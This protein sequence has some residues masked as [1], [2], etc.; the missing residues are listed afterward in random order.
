MSGEKFRKA[1]S[2]ALLTEYESEI[3]VCAK[4]KFSD[5]FEAE[6]SKLI[7]H[8]RKICYRLTNTRKKKIA[9]ISAAAVTAA[10]IG[11]ISILPVVKEKT[12][13]KNLIPYMYAEDDE[14]KY[15]YIE[16]TEEGEI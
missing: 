10:S 3:P 2:E 13:N 14:I 15:I 16:Y 4:H 9:W 5:N 7:K 1:I 11:I 8:R 12:D 6:M